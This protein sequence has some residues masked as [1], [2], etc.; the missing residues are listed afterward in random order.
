MQLSLS[1]LLSLYLQILFTALGAVLKV[2]V[3]DVRTEVLPLLA[4]LGCTVTSL[5]EIIVTLVAGIVVSLAP[6]LA[7]LVPTISALGLPDL[8]S[9]LGLSL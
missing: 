1:S 2:V 4:D 5:L 6:L 9:L 7:P 8:L 3:G